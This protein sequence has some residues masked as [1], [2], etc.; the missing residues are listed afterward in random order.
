[1]GQYWWELCHISDE[2]S[3]KDAFGQVMK[4]K[5]H[6][7]SVNCRLRLK[8]GDYLPF[9]VSA[10]KFLNPYS[11]DFEYVVATH[12]LVSGLVYYL[13]C[14]ILRLPLCDLLDTTNRGV[15]QSGGSDIY[16]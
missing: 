15:V 1:M 10:Y 9:N 12:T 5:D 13:L 6:S 7:I 4:L 3:V 2:G 16:I 8:S 14:Y 11:E